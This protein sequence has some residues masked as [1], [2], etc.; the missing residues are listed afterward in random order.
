MDTNIYEGAVRSALKEF[1]LKQ[2]IALSLICCHRVGS[3]YDRFSRAETWGNPGKL[4]NARTA[5]YNWLKGVNTDYKRQSASLEV[6]IPDSDDFGSVEATLAQVAAIAHYYMV[7]QL[8]S[9]EIQLTKLVLDRCLEIADVRIQELLDKDSSME[10]SIAAIESHNIYQ[11]EMLLHV[12]LLKG[13]KGSLDPVEFVD[14]V[15]AVKKDKQEQFDFRL[16]EEN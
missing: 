16:D 3:Y 5:V 15:L 9:K 8:E 13:I 10:P 4:R 2:A 12:E 14:K 6:E 1:S 11:K 7:E